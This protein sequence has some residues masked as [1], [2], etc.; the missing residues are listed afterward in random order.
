M[1]YQHL[2]HSHLYVCRQSLP[3][4]GPACCRVGGHVRPSPTRAAH[5]RVCILLAQLLFLHLVQRSELVITDGNAQS[6]YTELLGSY[7]ISPRIFLRLLEIKLLTLNL[8]YFQQRC[9]GLTAL[10]SL[11]LLPTL[12]CVDQTQ[13]QQSKV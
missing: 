8:I 6:Q 3:G 9:S 1:P 4:S 10:T 11:A 2:L 7:L 13:L 12:V 5:A